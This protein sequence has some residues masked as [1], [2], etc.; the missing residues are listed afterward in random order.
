A[1]ELHVQGRSV[2]DATLQASSL[3]LRPIL[4]TS[5][6]FIL[7]VL[8]LCFASGAGA[9][10]RRSLGV[11]V[12]SGMLGV[13]LFGII[14]T[15]VFFYVIQGIGETRLFSGAAVQWTLSCLFGAVIGGV[16]AYFLA[17]L[18]VIRGL[19]R[20]WMVTTGCSLGVLAVAAVRGVHKALRT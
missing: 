2:F 11:A 16:V 3:R 10:M 12:F 4:M 6:A 7:G 9:E 8:P 17:R 15:P 5:F 18:G 19:P 14:M 20:I 13:T 1:K